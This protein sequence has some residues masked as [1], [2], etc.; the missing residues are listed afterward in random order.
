MKISSLRT[1][2]IS[3][4]LTAMI[5]SSVA[6]IRSTATLATPLDSEILNVMAANLNGG[7]SVPEQA[8]VTAPAPVA[9]AMLTNPL[10]SNDAIN[11]LREYT[12]S[13]PNGTFFNAEAAQML[14]LAENKVPMKQISTK[15]SDELSDGKRYFAVSTEENADDIFLVV[16][17]NSAPKRIYWMNSKLVLIAALIDSP[18]NPHLI[19]STKKGILSTETVDDYEAL[20][21]FWTKK[22]NKLSTS[23]TGNG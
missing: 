11:L 16:E 14:G 18:G 12:L 4:Y 1:I 8:V 21:E 3:A 2:A 20:L 10:L 22:A 15:F 17:N 7:L 19:Y 13:K 6:P 5:T 23:A 9:V